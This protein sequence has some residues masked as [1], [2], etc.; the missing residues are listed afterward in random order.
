VDYGAFAIICDES[1]RNLG[2]IGLMAVAAM[3]Q[4]L[5][6]ALSKNAFRSGYKCSLDVAF[7]D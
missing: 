3:C 1:G 5:R 7:S 4:T 6:P 2:K